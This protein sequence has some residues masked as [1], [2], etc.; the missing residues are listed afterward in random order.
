MNLKL[1]DITISEEYEKLVPSLSQ[2]EY[3]QLKSSIRQTDYI[4]QS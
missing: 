2:E 4:F 1:E 3:N